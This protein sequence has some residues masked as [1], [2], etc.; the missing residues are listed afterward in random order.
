MLTWTPISASTELPLPTFHLNP[1]I[2][3][4]IL[5]AITP[6]S[7]LATLFNMDSSSQP[8]GSLPTRYQQS[9]GSPEAAWTRDFETTAT[10]NPGLKETKVS[11]YRQE[12]YATAS[13]KQDGQLALGL[14]EVRGYRE[15]H[16]AFQS[17][18]LETSEPY[19]QGQD[20]EQPLYVNPKQFHR[21]LKRRVARER[22]KQVVGLP[23]KHRKP[24]LHES[25]HN[26]AARRPRDPKGHFL[27]LEQIKDLE[28][29]KEA[30]TAKVAKEKNP[31]G[32]EGGRSMGLP[33]RSESGT[34]ENGLAAANVAAEYAEVSENVCD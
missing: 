25:R 21:I 33:G 7:L 8:Y 19:Q 14:T 5:S 3:L 2:F 31:R 26:H 1:T 4:T 23:S 10:V 27:S 30:A 22:L 34:R 24:Y 9:W 17:N 11:P 13:K 15:A 6:L 18:A 16:D 12:T 32:N 29:Q 28:K 20:E